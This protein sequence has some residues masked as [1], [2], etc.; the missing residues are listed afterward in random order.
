MWLTL[1]VAIFVAYNFKWS[2]RIE[3]SIADICAL[4]FVNVAMLMYAIYATSST[5]ASIREKYMIR[6]HRCYDLEDCICATFCM[7][8]T[9]CQMARHTADYTKYEA[10]C[11]TETGLDEGAALPNT[12]SNVSDTNYFCT[13]AQEGEYWCADERDLV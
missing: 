13:E 9:I 12:G 2:Q 8:C 5:R 10:A 6:E 4:A 3:L 11:C 1:N 7:P